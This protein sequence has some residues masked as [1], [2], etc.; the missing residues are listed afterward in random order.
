M[1]RPTRFRSPCAPGLGL[2]AC[3]CM[4]RVLLCRRV[5]LDADEMAHLVAHPAHRRGVRQLDRLMH[6]AEAEGADGRLL[7]VGVADAALHIRDAHGRRCILCHDGRSYAVAVAAFAASSASSLLRRRPKYETGLPR[8]WAALSTDS[9]SSG[10]FSA[11][12]TTL[13]GFVLPIVLVS[14]SWMP[15]ASMT[16]RT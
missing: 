8:R 10:A 12:R 5:G 15:A 7:I 1:P 2:R 16:A 9:S 4:I 13:T 11:A 3:C 14:T 6:P